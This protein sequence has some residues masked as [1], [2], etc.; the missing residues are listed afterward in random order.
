VLQARRQ[1]RLAHEALFSVAPAVQELLQRD[2][3]VQALVPGVEHA[4]DAPLRD[5]AGDRVALAVDDGQARGQARRARV[6]RGFFLGWAAR[7]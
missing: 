4:P 3:S 1:Q 5:L 2:R 7:A 6:L